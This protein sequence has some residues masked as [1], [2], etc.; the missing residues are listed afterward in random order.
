MGQIPQAIVDVVPEKDRDSG[1]W[2][3]VTFCLE[4]TI[5]PHRGQASRQKSWSTSPKTPGVG[6]TA[7]IGAGVAAAMCVVNDAGVVV[8][9]DGERSAFDRTAAPA[10]QVAVTRR[11]SSSAPMIT[12]GFGR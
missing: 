4:M 10:A 6:V 12:G 9:S 2:Y 8:E 7:D 1:G 11:S 3:V 5:R